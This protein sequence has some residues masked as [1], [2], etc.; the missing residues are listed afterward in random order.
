MQ[1]SVIIN[2]IDEQKLKEIIKYAGLSGEIIP[3]PLQLSTAV[4]L[5]PYFNLSFSLSKLFSSF[6]LLNR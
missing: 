4:G 5:I 1:V 3:L 2:L 6:Y